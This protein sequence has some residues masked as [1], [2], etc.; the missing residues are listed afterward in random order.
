M[1][2]S[3]VIVA[4]CVPFIDVPPVEP[5]STTGRLVCHARI[6]SILGH[7]EAGFV[8]LYEFD[9]WLNGEGHSEAYV[10]RCG[11]PPYEATTHNGYTPFDVV[12]DAYAVL[13]HQPEWFVRPAVVPDIN[14][15]PGL[16]A[17]R[18]V[19]P[20]LDYS[21]VSGTKLG[22]WEK[23]GLPKPWATAK[24][25]HQT[26]LAKG[27]SITH[28]H[29]KLAGANAKSARVSIHEVR[30]GVPPA[31]WKQI[32]PE[33]IREKLGSLNDN[34]VG[35]RSGDLPTVPGRR[36]ALRVEGLG[37]PGENDISMVVHRDA[38]GPGYDQ[39]TGYADGVAQEYDIYAT[40]SSDSD[41]T[42]IPYMRI[43]DIKPGQL[44]GGGT[45]SQTWVA[46]GK[47]LAATDFLV[48]WG[49]KEKGVKAEIRVHE[50][51]P[52]G[53]Q[54]GIAKRT[55]AAWWG[56]G[57]GFLG[58]AWEPGEVELQPGKTYCLEFVTVPPY[59]GYSAGVVNHP[60]NAYPD[61]IA[62][63]DGKPVPDKDLEMTI[64]E[65]A[66]PEKPRKLEPP[67]EP[68]GRNL[69][70]NGDF[71]GGVPSQSDAADPPGWKRWNTGPTAFWYG[72]YGRKGSNASRVIGGNINGT[73]IDGGF[74][75][76]VGG[77]NPGKRYCLSG[78]TSSSAQT[79][80]R[81]LSAVG[82]DPT[83]QVAD[84]KAATIVWGLTGR[85]SSCYEQIVFHDIRPKGDAI[86]IWTRGHNKDAGNL[87]FTVDFDDFALV[88]E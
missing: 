52:K 84:P 79:D 46:K 4:F 44:G 39:G 43:R 12:P 74:V 64:V 27:T 6:P 31:Q 83:G 35:W 51:N 2:E 19:I 61:G 15:K 62:F 8:E 40:I 42:V 85:L 25:F 49:G 26:F 80:K 3:L 38:V 7:P 5:P 63:C 71:E 30:E 53:K 18:N 41:G 70:V 13:L 36:Y 16:N 67:Y 20:A 75:Q 69:L 82:Y 22:P 60:D 77:L 68:K 65:Y 50:S 81:Y 86:S 11:A 88:E 9:M 32:G 29:F 10:R 78:W 48:A 73:K 21:C 1:V 34:W 58:A 54:I 23:P 14:V 33:R 45:W 17:D 28:A 72:K 56:P 24:V 76:R 57:Y 37:R 55:E 47:A 59:K 66:S 87:I